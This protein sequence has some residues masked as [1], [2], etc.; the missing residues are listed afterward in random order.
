MPMQATGNPSSGLLEKFYVDNCSCL[1]KARDAVK[2]AESFL[3]CDNPIL[4]K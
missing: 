1:S 3:K 4:Y 2:N